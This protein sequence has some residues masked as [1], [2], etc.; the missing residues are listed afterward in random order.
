[1]K[2]NKSRIYVLLTAM[3]FCFIL[4]ATGALAQEKAKPCDG[5]IA[6][7]CQDVVPG[8]GRIVKCLDARKA[9]VS[10]VCKARIKEVYEQ[11]T[12]LGGECYDE[13]MRF[14]PTVK[15]GEGRVAVCL[16]A[17]D[18]GMMPGPGSRLGDRCAHKLAELRKEAKPKK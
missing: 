4:V 12:E 13:I 18:R 15:P 7:F 16:S 2:I 11:A 5:D 17:Y 9:E 1:M 3:V 10:E 6:K 14:C 8:D